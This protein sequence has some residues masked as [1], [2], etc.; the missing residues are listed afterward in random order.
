M[1]INNGNFLSL[2]EMFVEFDPIMKE[3]VR[4]IKNSEIHAHYL[5][6]TIQNKLIEFLA[7]LIKK[8]K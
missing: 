8:S 6:N 7:F 3:H 1:K 5:S 2:I 4:R